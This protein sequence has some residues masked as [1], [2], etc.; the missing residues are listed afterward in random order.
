MNS[1]L[2]AVCVGQ[3]STI[4]QVIDCIDRNGEGVALV[5]ASCRLVGVVTDGDIRRA[6]LANTDLDS[7]VQ[8][9]LEHR[10]PPP[11]HA[12]V[13]A[14]VGTPD[15][16]LLRLMNQYGLRHIPL[17]DMEGCVA[18][19]ALL[20]NLTKEN[21]EMP[22][23]AVIMAGGYG[24]RLL[25]LTEDIPKPMLPIGDKPLMELIIEQLRSAGIR[26][27]TVTTHY[28]PE[29]IT[30][31]FRDGQRFGV[32]IDYIEEERPLGT[33]GAIGLLN[34]TDDPLLVINGDILTSLDF[35]AML[36]FHKEHRAD[37]TVAV[38]EQEFRLPYGVVETD[39]VNVLDITEKPS[40]RHFIN[41]GFYL[42]SPRVCEYIPSG[43]PLDMPDLV[44][45]LLAE[46]HRVV[47]FPVREYWIDIGHR[48]D[49]EQ[50]KAD[51]EKE[52]LVG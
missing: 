38:R 16:D 19:I 44:I 6:I 17:I 15:A 36:D 37:M 10:P 30:E 51:A 48:A 33:A 3:D 7:S 49:Y 1:D 46:G 34:G 32:K 21:Y 52:G 26:R 5:V 50:A 20:R 35:R 25:P 11:H 8:E 24:T 28:R 47:G 4:R 29:A 22:M 42:L 41:A 45:R 43:E 14:T 18:D 40:L 2:S 39:G 31:H 12:P 23:A 9:L 13:T 27:V